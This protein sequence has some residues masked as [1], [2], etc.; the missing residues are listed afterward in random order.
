[1]SLSSNDALDFLHGVVPIAYSDYVLL[2]RRWASL[3]RQAVQRL[4]NA[5]HETLVAEIFSG[6]QGQLEMFLLSLERASES[7]NQ[8]LAPGGWRRR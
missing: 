2:D 1:M 5:G 6:E 8:T 4:R 3:G 7:P